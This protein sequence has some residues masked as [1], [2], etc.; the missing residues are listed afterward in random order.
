MY[1]KSLVTSNTLTVNITLISQ[2][3]H[4]EVPFVS[5]ILI[6]NNLSGVTVQYTNTKVSLMKHNPVHRITEI[7]LIYRN[8]PRIYRNT[9]RIYRNTP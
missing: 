4:K 1:K 5:F 8:T 3:N 9:P 2:K 6:L 7:P